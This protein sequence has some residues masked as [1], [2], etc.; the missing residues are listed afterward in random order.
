[1]VVRRDRFRNR[2]KRGRTPH[3]SDPDHFSQYDVQVPPPHTHPTCRAYLVA[4]RHR[5]PEIPKRYASQLSHT[6]GRHVDWGNCGGVNSVGE[7]W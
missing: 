6:V 2:L 7:V 3:N 5:E 4:K 1:V